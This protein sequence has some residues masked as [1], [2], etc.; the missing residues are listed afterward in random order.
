MTR[1][2]QKQVLKAMGYNNYREYVAGVIWADI[3]DKVFRK[4]G[5]KCIVCS[6]RATVIHIFYRCGNP[7]PFRVGEEQRNI[8][9]CFPFCF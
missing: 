2:E 7:Y 6:R 8:I 3:R 9:S 1:T 4:K 5:N